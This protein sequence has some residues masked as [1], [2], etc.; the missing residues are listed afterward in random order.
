MRARKLSL[1]T[2][3]EKKVHNLNFIKGGLHEEKI[4]RNN[5]LSQCRVDQS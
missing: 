4:V 3:M 5:V 1:G 2:L